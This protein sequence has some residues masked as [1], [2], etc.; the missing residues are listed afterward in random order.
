MTQPN[1]LDQRLSPLIAVRRAARTL[2]VVEPQRLADCLLRLADLLESN[3]DEIL[4]ANALD[5]ARMDEADP[6]Y[7][8]LRLSPERISAIATDTRNVAN[9]PCPLG[10]VL[11]RKTLD[12]GLRLS[13]L[14]V[15]IGV[16][17]V[18]FES[19]PNVAIDVAALCLKSGNAAVLKG[20][21]DA[22]DSNHALVKLIQQAL[23]E[24]DLP[25]HAVWLAPA[26]R[27]A[28]APL[29]AATDY[30]DVAIPRGS[31]GLINYVREVAKVPTIETGAG[32]VH[33]YV[34]ASADFDKAV[35][36]VA[37][38]KT[39]RVS[40]CN[41]LDTLLLHADWLPRLP[42]LV[43]GMAQSHGVEIYADERAY[44]A[45]DGHYAAPLHRATDEDFGREFLALKI[46]IKTVD[47]L[48]QALDHVACHSSKHSEAI[49]AQ[50]QT[51]VDRY[52][53]SVD[54]AAVYANAATTFT[55]GAQFQMGA[56]I[57]I[58]T[59]KLHARGPMAL[60]ELTSYKWIVIGDGQIRTD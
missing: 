14:R 21:R 58:S 43:A 16:V 11:E 3:A 10:E 54:A 55:D 12:N 59:Q 22:A 5:L 6:K 31:Q 60:P 36:I 45:L 50:D 27:D 29:L 42:A 39:R 57:G 23:T 44:S 2:S 26:E 48:D 13:K 18:V 24:H 1:K 51:I 53:K 37:N 35:A 17:A 4:A 30:I 32:I 25:A 28:V 33:V 19:R 40:V 47:S 34:D 56:E 38:S 9:L 52:L 15:P 7:D 20:S 8:R 41:A 46:S 49:V